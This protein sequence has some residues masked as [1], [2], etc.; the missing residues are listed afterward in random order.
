M[1]G[2]LRVGL[3]MK[4]IEKRDNSVLTPFMIKPLQTKCTVQKPSP[5]M[6]PKPV[7]PFHCPD[8]GQQKYFCQEC[9]SLFCEKA[10]NRLSDDCFSHVDF[11][12]EQHEVF[13]IDDINLEQFKIF[14]PQFSTMRNILAHGLDVL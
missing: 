11:G 10:I 7:V 6:K 3:Q 9:N 5:F 12:G 14:Q 2:N 8:G 4:S 13:L 1:F